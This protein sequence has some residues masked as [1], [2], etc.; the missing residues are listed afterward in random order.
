MNMPGK[1]FRSETAFIAARK[2][3]HAN[4]TME[5]CKGRGATQ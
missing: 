1:V 5:H 3:A 4:L 2:E